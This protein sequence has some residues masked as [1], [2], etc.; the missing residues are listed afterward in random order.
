ML[1]LGV[2]A[3][4]LATW[5]CLERVISRLGQRWIARGGRRRGE[6]PLRLAGKGLILLATLTAFTGMASLALNSVAGFWRF[7]EALPQSV[8]TTH[9]L[10]ALPALSGPVISTIVI[11]CVATLIALALALAALEN[12]QRTG[13]HPTEGRVL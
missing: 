12:E 9:W 6:Q 7:P 2:T 11:A 8:T 10:R 13:R 5:W 4:A 1:Q 3:T